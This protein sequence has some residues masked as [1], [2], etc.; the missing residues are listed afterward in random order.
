MNKGMPMPLGGTWCVVRPAVW[1]AEGA[2]G[3]CH[4]NPSSPHFVQGVPFYPYPMCR[5]STLRAPSLCP[6]S[7]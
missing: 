3:G 7:A 1:C 6:C 2:L 5:T 4:L